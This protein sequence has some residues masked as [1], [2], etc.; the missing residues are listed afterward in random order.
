VLKG[1]LDVLPNV[2]LDLG[3]LVVILAH[4]QEALVHFV[5]AE[6]RVI[7]TLVCYVKPFERVV[8]PLFLF[9]WIPV[10]ITPVGGQ[11]LEDQHLLLV[12][13]QGMVSQSAIYFPGL[14]SGVYGQPPVVADRDR[15]GGP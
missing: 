13:L 5:V 3:F 4:F 14:E 10:A 7:V 12:V 9:E 6:V 15:A 11:I 1:T 8:A 2:V